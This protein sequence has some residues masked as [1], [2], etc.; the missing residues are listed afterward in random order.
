MHQVG[1]FLPA[2]FPKILLMHGFSDQYK[3]EFYVAYQDMRYKGES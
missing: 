1:Y 3:P 2:E